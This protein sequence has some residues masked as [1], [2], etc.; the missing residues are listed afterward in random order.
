[1]LAG[2][3]VSEEMVKRAKQKHQ[4]VSQMSMLTIA[5]PDRVFDT[6]IAVRSIKNLLDLTAQSMAVK[7]LTRVAAKRIIVVDS[8]KESGVEPPK[9]NLYL[10]RSWLLES[11]SRQGFRLLREEYFRLRFIRFPIIAS[12]GTVQLGSDEGFFVFDRSQGN[13]FEAVSWK[14]DEI[15]YSLKSLVRTAV[16]RLRQAAKRS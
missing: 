16:T 14:I 5:F 11:F 10:S 2:F 7:E 3:D 9:F 12:A 1:M 6:V 13:R 8:I 4:N 15:V